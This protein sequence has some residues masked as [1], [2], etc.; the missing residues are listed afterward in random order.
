[1]RSAARLPVALALLAAVSLTAACS[2]K[3]GPSDI[4][5]LATENFT[6]AIA[7]GGT[8]SHTFT[9]RYQVSYTDASVTVT[10]LT[11]VATGAAAP[12]TIGIAFGNINQGI[13]TRAPSYTNPAALLNQEQPTD[14]L[15]FIAGSYCVQ[16]FD[17]PTG[18]T[19]TE[20]LNYTL[21]VRHY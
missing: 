20:P 6:G 5:T 3:L 12:I 2:K 19:V 10:S 1:M 14:D 18:S 17:N 15:P 9:V 13:C 21:T 8:A 11:S 16:I 7:P 4:P